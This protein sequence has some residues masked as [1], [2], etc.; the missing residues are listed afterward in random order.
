M[1]NKL[2]VEKYRPQTI[3]DYVFID[4]KQEEQVRNWIESKTIPTLLF[5][6]SP[7]TGKTTLAKIL[8][9]QLEIDEYDVLE[10]NASRENSVDVMRDKITGFVQT[11]PFGDFKIVLLDEADYASNNAQAILRNLIET[12][13]SSVR[14]II[15]CNY[16]HKILPAL[17]SRCQGYHIEKVDKT[18][19]TTRIA[20]VLIKEEIEFE[21]EVLD[22]HVKDTYPAL[23]KCLN[24]CQLNSSSGV[25]LPAASDQGSSHEYKDDVIKL[26]KNKQYSKARELLC[27]N[28]QAS[29]ME[30]IIKWAYDH[31]DIW[32]ETEEQQDAA[33]LIIRDA[34]VNASF[35]A[36]HEINL[37][38]MFIELSQI[39]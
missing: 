25:L 39:S 8:I 9:N 7:G 36:D 38:A 33:I 21:L 11:M 26:F 6:G 28:V 24:S 13:Y 34:A 23:R 16:P 3:D 10:I 5:S 30:N 31:L 22:Q 15:T 14:F 19:F 1:K 32:G 17:H 35:V 4:K 20:T 37:S 2:W 27:A 18:E 29:D 12:Y